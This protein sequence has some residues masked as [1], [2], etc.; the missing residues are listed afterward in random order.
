MSSR[1][2]LNAAIDDPS[3]PDPVRA[4]LRASREREVELE[5]ACKKLLS[6]LPDCDHL[7]R[8]GGR[9]SRCATHSLD[10]FMGGTTHACAQHAERGLSPS[11]AGTDG[12]QVAELLQRLGL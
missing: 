10:H 5:R 11:S 2:E 4:L 6:N 1:Q 7:Y 8:N 9:C 3:L 12:Q